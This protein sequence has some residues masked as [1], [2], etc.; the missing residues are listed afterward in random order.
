MNPNM[1][2]K[3]CPIFFSFLANCDISGGYTSRVNLI[4]MHSSFHMSVLRV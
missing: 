2:L 4:L 1:I 3:A